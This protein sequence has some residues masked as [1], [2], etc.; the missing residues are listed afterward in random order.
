MNIRTESILETAIRDYIGDGKP[1]SSK[2]LVDRHRFGVKEATVRNEL[3]RL[4]KEGFLAQLHTS[5]G[6]VP[7]DKGYQFFV[8][9]TIDNVIDSQKILNGK[10][11]YL[12]EDLRGGRLRDFVRAF[13]EETG[14]LGIGRRENEEEVYKCGLDELFEQLDLEDREDF[15]EIVCDFEMIDRRLENSGGRFFEVFSDPQIFI[16]RKSPI[17]KS[18]NLSVIIDNYDIDNQK[19]LVAVIGPKRMNY[20]KNLRLFKLLRDFI[21]N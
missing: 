20:N 9:N 14:L 13:S 1:V 18:E 7:T 6:R 12:A 8:Q 4:T 16:G 19:I 2:G 10:Y 17:T 5:G 15:Q 11:E 21:N 3:N